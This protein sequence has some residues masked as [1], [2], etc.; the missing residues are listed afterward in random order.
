MAGGLYNVASF[1]GAGL[2][3]VPPAETKWLLRVPEGFSK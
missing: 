1:V 3:R 2:M